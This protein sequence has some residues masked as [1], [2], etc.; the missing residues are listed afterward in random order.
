[1]RFS[2]AMSSAT[3]R[4]FARIIRHP[5]FPGQIR[6]RPLI[7][8]PAMRDPIARRLWSSADKATI[9][10]QFDPRNVC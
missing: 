5:D 4:I 3:D 8:V 1:M 7:K 2:I 6:E 9:P 10:A